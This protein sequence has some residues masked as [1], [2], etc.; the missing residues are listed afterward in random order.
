MR[1]VKRIL[2]YVL[3]AA[4][5]LCLSGCG[6]FESQI[7]KAA[8]KMDALQSFHF[9]M[10]MQLEMSVTM[11]GESVD[12]DM[13]MDMDVEPEKPA[14][15][16]NSLMSALKSTIKIDQNYQPNVKTLQQTKIDGIKTVDNRYIISFHG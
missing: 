13:D 8:K 14:Q 1:K 16:V 4:M 15:P 2:A 11:L 12:M 7:T 5:L 6:S 3:L 9:D 10:D